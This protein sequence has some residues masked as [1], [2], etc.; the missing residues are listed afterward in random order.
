M[1]GIELLVLEKPLVAFH[2]PGNVP[3]LGHDL[4]VVGRGDEPPFCFLG[5]ALVFKGQRGTQAFL[6]FYRIFRWHFSLLVKVR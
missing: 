5:I 4:L 1:D 3:G 6:Q 2:V